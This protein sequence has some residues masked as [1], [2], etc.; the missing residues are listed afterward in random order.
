MNDEIH[1]EYLIQ[2]PHQIDG[3]VLRRVIAAL[4]DLGFD[5]DVWVH[6]EDCKNCGQQDT[7]DLRA[8]R[9]AR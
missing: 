2:L 1:E 6:R 4:M 7:I 8:S 5:V 9:R 3:D